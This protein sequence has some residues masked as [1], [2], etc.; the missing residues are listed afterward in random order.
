MSVHVAMVAHMRVI[1]LGWG[2]CGRLNRGND[3]LPSLHE[4]VQFIQ[5]KSVHE[6]G[7][8]K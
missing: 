4:G 2:N 3:T 7:K 6:E 8:K 1:S 5:T